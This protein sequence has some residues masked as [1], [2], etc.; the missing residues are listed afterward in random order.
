MG[1]ELHCV[2]RIA[3]ID[4]ANWAFYSAQLKDLCCSPAYAQM[5]YHQRLTKVVDFVYMP[6]EL[7]VAAKSD[8]ERLQDVAVLCSLIAEITGPETE[9]VP[10]EIKNQWIA[11]KKED[12]AFLNRLMGA[13][14]RIEAFRLGKD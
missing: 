13:K 1:L 10:D 3:C 4:P 14:S 7:F 2:E 9:V 5:D 6:E 12:I 11:A 8:W